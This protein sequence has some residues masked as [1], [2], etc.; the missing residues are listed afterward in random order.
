MAALPLWDRKAQVRT[1]GTVPL[2]LPHEL[3]AT[4]HS[5]TVSVAGLTDF[6]QLPSALQERMGRFAAALKVDQ[7]SLC[8]LSV[9]QDGVPFNSDR[10]KSVEVLSLGILTCGLLDMR[11]PLAVVPK[12]CVLKGEGGTIDAI[13]RVCAWSFAA[14]ATGCWPQTRSDGKPFDDTDAWRKKALGSAMPLP[15]GVLL[16]IKGD[17]SALKSVFRFPGWRDKTGCCY[18][19]DMTPDRIREVASNSDWRQ[20]SH[21]LCH[22][23]LLVRMVADGK[24][25]SPAFNIPFVTTETF[26]MDW[27]HTTDLG[28]SLEF[29]GGILAWACDYLEG[30]QAQKCSALHLRMKAYYKRTCKTSCLLELKPTMIWKQPGAYARLRAKAGEARDLIDFA[31]E[32]T[33]ELFDHTQ[34]AAATAAAAA[35]QLQVCYQQLSKEAFHREL[36]EQAALRFA[37]L[38]VALGDYSAAHGW[39]TFPAKPK[40]HAFLEL[41]QTSTPP[42]AFWTYTEESWGGRIALLGERRG[43]GSTAKAVGLSVFDRFA[44]QHDVPEL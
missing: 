38:Y 14:L 24:S 15:R 21:R 33:N 29:L 6:D 18:R 44:A 31:V 3:V 39:K 42:S 7:E 26:Q 23:D 32:V 9:W 2:W 8:G 1:E 19:C 43:G 35:L 20:P 22:A 25:I 36:L 17:W 40:L 28:I 27:L 34:P 30:N 41:V 10:S 37:L 5:R 16:E 12:H 13:F 4:L 11:L